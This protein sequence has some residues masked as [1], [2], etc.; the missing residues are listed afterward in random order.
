MK[1]LLS[2]LLH[3]LNMWL[4]DED[5]D[6]GQRIAVLL[7]VAAMLAGMLFFMII[8]ACK[9]ILTVTSPPAFCK[10]DLAYNWKWGVR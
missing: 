7:V 3:V 10:G 9:Q 2:M 6:W 8:P 1:T 4:P 5:C